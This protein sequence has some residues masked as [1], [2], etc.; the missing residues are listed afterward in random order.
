M[1]RERKAALAI[2]EH[3][4]HII[5]VMVGERRI[6]FSVP[7]EV[8]QNY[9]RRPLRNTDWAAPCKAKAAIALP[10]QHRKPVCARHDQIHLSILIHIP[11]CDTPRRV[12]DRYRRVGCGN[13]QRPL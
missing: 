7:I 5:A 6:E 13:E 2:A 4:Y 8:S 10:E 12:A 3:K 1:R 11:Q 9:F